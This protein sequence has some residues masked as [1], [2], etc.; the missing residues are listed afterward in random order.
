MSENKNTNAASRRRVLSISATPA[1]AIDPG[2]DVIRVRTCGG[3]GGC[4]RVSRVRGQAANVAI[5]LPNPAAATPAQLKPIDQYKWEV[6]TDG[7]A[8]AFPVV[9]AATAP[10]LINGAASVQ[11]PGNFSHASIVFDSVSGNYF[12]NLNESLAAGENSAWADGNS[13]VALVPVAQTTNATAFDVMA[14]ILAAATTGFF[15]GAAMLSMTG[16]TAD[17]LVCRVVTRTQAATI[18]PLGNNTA[19]GTGCQ[20]QAAAGGLTYTGA[21]AAVVHALYSVTIL[22]GVLTAV[23]SWAGRLSNTAAQAPFLVPSN[24]IF[25][26]QHSNSAHTTTFGGSGGTA[27]GN[28]IELTEA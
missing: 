28:S 2:V 5:T 27:Q 6:F 13:T 19:S 14:A 22:T 16:T 20:F 12:C 1:A 10:C 9:I 17:V 3:P 23:F 11:M 18:L 8:G 26:I 24:V 15:R 7:N 21:P 25:A 4:R